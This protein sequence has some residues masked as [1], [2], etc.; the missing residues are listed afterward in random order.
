MTAGKSRVAFECT[1]RK[2]FESGE[3]IYFWTFTF[4]ELHDD[5]EASRL[6]SKFLDHLRKVMG[7]DWGGVRV[8]ELH[9]THGVH[10][11]AL[12]NRRLAVDVVRRVGRCH[13]I[14]RIHVKRADSGSVGYLSKYL[15]KQRA[16]PLCESGRN[17][18]RWAAFGDI[19]RTR[20][21]DIVYESPMWNYRREQGF[22]WLGWNVE[23]LLDRAWD[24]G[25]E[26]FRCVYN[27]CGCGRVEEA[28]LLVEGR[29][30]LVGYDLVYRPELGPF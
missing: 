20:C 29:L 15:R 28:C 25:V 1:A 10:Y 19:D 7:G 22:K 12:L 6:F 2:L 18:R 30:S 5:W 21:C 17:A 3:Q 23:H 11:H 26:T 16:G 13:G 27:R 9:K 24:Y 4:A 8:V 14:G